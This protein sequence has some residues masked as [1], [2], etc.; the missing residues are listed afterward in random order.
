MALDKQAIAD[1]RNAVKALINLATLYRH[2]RN[3]RA[4][5]KTHLVKVL[6]NIHKVLEGTPARAYKRIAIIQVLAGGDLTRSELEAA[7]P[8]SARTIEKGLNGTTW[9]QFN[10]VKTSGSSSSYSKKY[11]DARLALIPT[12]VYSRRDGHKI[13]YGLTDK[14]REVLLFL[15]KNAF[16]F[17]HLEGGEQP[18]KMALK[19]RRKL[20]KTLMDK[21][22]TPLSPFKE[23]EGYVYQKLGWCVF[24]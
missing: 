21:A 24:K 8:Y 20:A 13:Y 19:N 15:E 7:I 10:K 22:I 18:P 17:L 4:I 11:V 2:N 1:K 12:Y 14:G 9:R 23:F 3:I 5:P 16:D 6:D